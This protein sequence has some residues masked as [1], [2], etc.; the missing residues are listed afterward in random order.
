MFFDD[1]VAI[2]DKQLSEWQGNHP[3]SA[4]LFNKSKQLDHFDF[5]SLSSSKDKDADRDVA[6]PK[7]L[8][9]RARRKDLTR[10]IAEWMIKVNPTSRMIASYRR[11]LQCCEVLYQDKDGRLTTFYC[12]ER[13]C[14][15]CG[16]IRTAQLIESYSEEI[17]SWGDDCFM[18][19]LTLPNCNGDELKQYIADMSKRFTL[20][21]RSVKRTTGEVRAIRKI[22]CTYSEDGTFHPHIHALIK[23][24]DTANAI[25]DQWKKKTI[26]NDEYLADVAQDVRKCRPGSVKEVFKYLTKIS[27]KGYFNPEMLDTVICAMFGRRTLQNYGFTIAKEE[28]LENI[29][30]DELNLDTGTI[31]TNRIGD[32][33]QWEWIEA[34]GW[35][36]I[37]T[38]EMLTNYSR[39]KALN[40]WLNRL[41]VIANKQL[42]TKRMNI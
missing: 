17:D 9:K 41:S 8:Y 31:A 28:K 38:G 6:T 7:T 37:G 24:V 34:H 15:L 16:A 25:R 2:D 33:V 18:V 21:V 3:N 10:W 22:E 12:S 40:R 42:T 36:D 4:S 1:D 27:S 26:K 30:D 32:E 11:M 20:C 13:L 29:A 39:P 19:T 35:L 23:G 14:P 5:L